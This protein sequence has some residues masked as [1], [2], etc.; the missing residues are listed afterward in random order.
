[1]SEQCAFAWQTPM[2]FREFHEANPQIFAL[3][4]RFAQDAKARR[5][6]FSARTIL[7]R[8]R[9][10]TAVETDDPAGFKINNNWSPF[11]ARLLILEDSSFDGFFELRRSKADIEV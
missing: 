10:Y 7:H 1:M 11:Y 8:I 3:F 5:P 4:K 9:W 6:R 2:T